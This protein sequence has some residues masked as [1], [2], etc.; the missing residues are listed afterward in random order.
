M[1]TSPNILTPTPLQ[2]LERGAQSST[3]CPLDVTIARVLK[4]KPAELGFGTVFSDHMLIADYEPSSGW[5]ARIQPYGPLALDPATAALII[6]RW[7]GTAHSEE[8]QAEVA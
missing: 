1:N 7:L 4:P 2:S 6:K 8:E 3:A 5:A